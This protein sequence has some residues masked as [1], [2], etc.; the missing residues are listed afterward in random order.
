MPGS[1]KIGHQVTLVINTTVSCLRNANALDRLDVI[2]ARA[3]S[4]EICLTNIRPLQHHLIQLSNCT[5]NFISDCTR[6]ALPESHLWDLFCIF[7]AK[8]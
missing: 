4:M 7:R 8:M 1:E 3:L 2:S 5:L 6:L